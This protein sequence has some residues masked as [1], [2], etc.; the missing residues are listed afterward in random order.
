MTTYRIV[1][2][3]D[4]GCLNHIKS[5]DNERPTDTQA[6]RNEKR[7][8]AAQA[9]KQRWEQNCLLSA[10]LKIVECDDQGFPLKEG[11]YA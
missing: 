2:A 1:D 3:A 5:A 11:A 9:M 10:T 4:G 7:L 6:T 8:F